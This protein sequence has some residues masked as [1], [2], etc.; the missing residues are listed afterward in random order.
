MNTSTPT[1]PQPISPPKIYEP[2]RKQLL[3]SM[4]LVEL[5]DARQ[6]FRGLKALAVRVDRPD[7]LLYATEIV[8][9]L[10]DEIE[11]RRSDGGR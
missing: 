5:L 10:T 4:G 11:R 7:L 1:L 6:H 9:A 8:D 3:E 2:Q